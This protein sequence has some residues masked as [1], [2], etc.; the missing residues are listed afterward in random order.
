[1]SAPVRSYPGLEKGRELTGRD[2]RVS[3]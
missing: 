2:A 3:E 1:M